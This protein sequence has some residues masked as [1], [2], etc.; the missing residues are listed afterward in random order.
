VSISLTLVNLHSFPV[1]ILIK[2]RPTC[3]GK[4]GRQREAVH[5]DTTEQYCLSSSKEGLQIGVS[6]DLCLSDSRGYALGLVRG[7]AL[8]ACLKPDKAKGG[9]ALTSGGRKYVS[10]FEDEASRT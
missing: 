1:I 3:S 6:H 4:P 7:P 5:C 10:R 2:S 9:R 8:K